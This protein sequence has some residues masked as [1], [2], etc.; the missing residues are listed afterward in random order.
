[1][2]SRRSRSTSA[3]AKIDRPRARRARCVRGPAAP[4]A[5]DR[6]GGGRAVRRRFEGTTVAA[7]QAALEGIAPACRADR[8]RRRQGTGLRAAQGSVDD[9]LPR[10]AADRPRC[11]ADRAC[12]RPA[13]TARV[14]IGRHAGSGRRARD[15]RIASPATPCCCRRH[16]QA[17]TS[18]ATTS[19]AASASPTSSRAAL[20][21]DGA[22]VR[23]I[24]ARRST[25]GLRKP[26]RCVGAL[27]RDPRTM[28]AYDASLAW[29]A[30]LLLAIGLV[31]VY[32]AS[33][34]MAEA[35]AHTGYRA[36]YFLARHA[37]VRRA[38]ASSPRS[39]RSRCPS[40][41]GSA[42]RP[43]CSSVGAAAAR[44]RAGAGDRQVGQRFA[45]LAVAR[46]R[47][48]PA[49]RVHEARRR[50]LRGELRGAQ[51][52]VPACRAAVE[53]DAA[54]RL[55]C[56]CSR[57]WS[58]IGGLLLLEPDFGAFVV[59]VAIALR[60]PVPGRPRLAAVPRPGAAA[61]GRAWRRSS[62]LRRTG[63]SGSTAFL[64]PWSDPFGKGYQLSHSLIAFGRGEWIG[65]GSGL[66]RREAPVPAGSAHRFPA[67]RDRRG[68][69]L[70]RR[71]G[72]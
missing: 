4:D 23:R 54:A 20:A 31:M 43:G 37:H 64:D 16:A 70:R 44:A 5:A 26:R 27:P 47:Q 6:R 21:E 28:L 55:S 39:S 24:D 17:S 51:G 32:S 13:R 66:E 22:C 19:S 46:R 61:A 30:L 67:R 50:A 65:V 14:E 41:R 10:R 62:S 29:A 9:A 57:S 45:A 63:C 56:R 52:G 48:R 42:A 72:W 3:V 58:L 2:R 35:S 68:A 7:T 59:I 60:H 25:F 33:I 53:A 38:S 34:A 1:M 12:A 40:R 69:R 15:A 18:S 8:R 49:V 71:R 11:A 36:W